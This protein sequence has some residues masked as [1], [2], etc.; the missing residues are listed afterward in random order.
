[1]LGLDLGTNS[2]GWALIEETDGEPTGLVDLGVRVF[3]MAIED[4]TPTPKNAKRRQA[5]GA[6]RLTK[7]RKMR[8]IQLTNLL[9]K[10]GLLPT[11]V[12]ASGALFHDH[13]H[14][15]YELRARALDEKL[16]PHEIGRAL[17]HLNQRRGYQSNRR[18]SR[19]DQVEDPE[20]KALVLRGE[21][22]A[23]EKA[24]EKEARAKAKSLEKGVEYKPK[25]DDDSAVL[26]EIEELRERLGKPGARTLGELLCHELR[27]GARA[28]ARHTDRQMYKEEFEAIWSAQQNH[29][30]NLLTDGLRAEAFETI[31]FQRPLRTQGGNKGKCEF[32]TGRAR[33]AKAHPDAQLIRILQD[34][35]HLTYQLPGSH[36]FVPLTNEQRQKLTQTLHEQQSITWSKV[37]TLLQLPRGTA[38]N[39]ESSVGEKLVGNLTHYEL[40]KRSNCKWSTYSGKNR[41]DLITDILTI[42]KKDALVRRLRT[43]WGFTPQEAYD[44][45]TYEPLGGTA[46]LSLKAIRKIMPHMEAGKNYPDA[47]QEAKYL[48]AD[49]RES[50]KVERLPASPD[51]RNPVVNR[52]LAEVR[53]LVNAIV[54]AYGVPERV[55]VEMARDLS[56]SKKDKEKL[57]KQNKANRQSNDEAREKLMEQKIEQPSRDDLI[58]FRLWKEC[59]GVCPYT[60]NAIPIEKLFTLDIDVEHILPYSRSLDDSFNNKTLCYANENRNVKLNR[61]PWEAY[62]GTDK[63]EPMLERVQK[64]KG[65]RHKKKLFALQEIPDGF[66]HRQLN[67]TR[68]ISR[69]VIGYLHVLGCD[70]QVTKGEATAA[71]RHRWGLETVL[72][73]EGK[74]RDD[75]RH[76]AVDA[77]VVALTS[78]SLFQKITRLSQDK[79]GGL[80]RGDW[81]LPDPWKDFRNNVMGRTANVV[82][83]HQINRRISGALHQETAYGWSE[84]A[85]KFVVR[86]PISGLKPAEIERIRDAR[87]QGLVQQRYDEKGEAGLREP[88]FITNKHG[89]EKPVRSV[90]TYSYYVDP[91]KHAGVVDELGRTYKYYLL[92]SN[93]HAVVFRDKDTGKSDAQVVSTLDVARR[94]SKGLPVRQGADSK[95]FVFFLHAGDTVLIDGDH[96]PHVVKML[97]Q[98]KP[99]IMKLQPCNM[100]DEESSM[101][102]KGV[103]GAKGLDRVVA[104]VRV[105]RLGRVWPDR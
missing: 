3:Q 62:G 61:T 80:W 32:E 88:F 14:H 52:A 48:R 50:K 18:S 56:L 36:E 87:I 1:M 22:E 20:V 31:F 43:R 82:V 44:L 9:Q 59:E 55:T 95:D 13:N 69:Q 25:E 101:V 21:Q 45:A 26:A 57:D 67:D 79:V 70:V 96:R 6:R 89:Q 76:H 23:V 4:K 41:D 24:R 102:I 54:A 81:E 65:S 77:L 27:N 33:C 74:N 98:A 8:R 38:F 100:A 30:P 49:Q 103:S 58:K 10:H 83:S 86:K 73:G 104:K 53:H 37:A 99:L 91:T 97:S 28:R 105:D 84:T 34:V 66:S 12:E 94:A 47:C 63:W 39:L 64:F 5:R 7:R 15:P 46:S 51:L 29:Y 75:H 85:K 72:G 17:F 60:G 11:D 42:N 90:R 93:H 78:R 40:Q 92:G 71:L 35:A 16:H 2:I 19:L 68:Y